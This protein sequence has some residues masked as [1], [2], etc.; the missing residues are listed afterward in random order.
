[1]GKAGKASASAPPAEPLRRGL[2]FKLRLPP[3][4]ADR[5]RTKAKR[6]GLPQNRVVVSELAEYPR[7][8]DVGTLAERISDT[9]VLLARYS[10]RISGIEITENLLAAVDAV[11]KA[12]SLDAV[13]AAVERLRV[14]H[15]RISTLPDA[16]RRKPKGGT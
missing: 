6:M 10:S 3:D 12:E 11:L 4:I 2:E 13:Q 7:L 9:E 1:M 16:A 15:H 14:E 5:I 8:N